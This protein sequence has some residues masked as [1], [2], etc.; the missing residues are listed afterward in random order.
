M[1]RTVLVH[2][3]LLD[4]HGIDLL[5]TLVD[6]GQLLEEAESA[7][8]AYLRRC[9]LDVDAWFAGRVSVNA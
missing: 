7:A 8:T 1:P 9:G 6:E 5:A 3:V 4:N 2:C